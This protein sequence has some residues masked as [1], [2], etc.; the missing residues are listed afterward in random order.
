MDYLFV[1]SWS[2]F[3][4]CVYTFFLCIVT[5]EYRAKK[6]GILGYPAI[7]IF[8][9]LDTYH[10][11]IIWIM[12]VTNKEIVQE[13]LPLGKYTLI[14][15]AKEETVKPGFAVYDFK[16][17]VRKKGSKKDWTVLSRRSLPDNFQ[18]AKHGIQKTMQRL[19][20]LA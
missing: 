12:I 9:L 5:D 11:F 18:V 16:S 6:M 14:S 13:D 4:L 19:A 1:S 3:A 20:K 2:V 17:V 8:F 10:Q 15:S 7:I